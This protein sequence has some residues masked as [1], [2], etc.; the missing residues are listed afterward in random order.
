[1]IIHENPLLTE[2][3]QPYH[4]P[5]FD[6]VEDTDYA[7]AYAQGMAEH[8]REVTAIANAPEPPTFEN[9]VVALERSGQLLRRVNRLFSNL[10]SANTNPAL[11]AI[12]TAVAPQL[13]AH[14]DE[15]HLNPALFARIASLHE[16]R[17]QLGLDAESKYLLERYQK[18]FVRGGANLAEADKIKL[19]AINAELA[20]L[21]TAFNQNLLKE[22][23]SDALVV[24]DRAQLTGLT[25]TEIVAAQAA[26]TAQG[27]EGKFAL[28]LFNTANQPALA[29]LRDRTLRQRLMETSLARNSH[30]GDFDTTAAV[31]RIARLRAERAVLLGYA[32]HAEYQLEDQTAGSVETVNQLLANL[33]VP[34]V[35]NARREAAAMQAII[36]QEKGGFAL[37]SWDWNFYAEKVRQEQYAFDE[38]E[39]RPYFELERVLFDGVFYAAT[40]FYGITFQ[41]R[42]DLLVYH[43]DVRVFEVFD[44]DGAPLAL[45]LA[46]FYAR[47]AKRGGAWMNAY[48]SQSA[49]LGEKPVV[50]NH[51]NIPKP[52]AGEPTLL[53][54]DEVRT[55]FHEFGHALHG[56]FSQVQYPRFSGT[57]VPRDFVE[58]PSQVYEMWIFWPEIVKHY[59]RHHE[60]GE[61]LPQALLDKVLAAEKFNQGFKT[62]EYLAAALLDQAWHQ[63]SPEEVPVDVLAYEAAALA[64]AGVDFAPV[65]PRYRSPFFS[66]SFG[67]GYSAGYYSYLWSEVLD[68]ASVDWIKTHGG[69]TRENGDCLRRTV[70]SRGGSADAL[71]LYR[72][73]TGSAPEVQPLLKRRGLE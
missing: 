71:G 31:A 2:S 5:P 45:F 18:D 60:T 35:A 19:K 64:R 24:E 51:Q 62:T 47:P 32:H 34:A 57:S 27:R 23:N 55:A 4:L 70:L 48:V 68:A 30:G 42:P 8:L 46:D 73:F 20:A 14:W 22:K 16:R 33:A 9:C 53:T 25:D 65:P 7:P 3:P 26:A 36:D 21:Q 29:S 44:A 38:T 59:A 12:E 56:I 28:P 52:P 63:L 61:P 49:L 41:E 50:G 11:Q 15:I 58:F 17:D 10:A 40:R 67:G 1:M 54:L 72:D 66:H 37:A 69:L 39:I 6:R 13:A 43:P